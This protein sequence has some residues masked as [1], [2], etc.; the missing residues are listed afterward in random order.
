LSRTVHKPKSRLGR[1]LLAAFGVALVVPAAAAAFT[2]IELLVVIAIVG[3]MTGVFLPARIAANDCDRERISV[4]VTLAGDL[5]A[6]ILVGRPDG[7]FDYHIHPADL[8]GSGPRGVSVRF[9]GAA[10]GT[11]NSGEPF[12]IEL[13]LIGSSDLGPINTGAEVSLALIPNPGERTVDARVLRIHALDPCD[14]RIDSSDA[15]PTVGAGTAASPEGFEAAA[16]GGTAAFAGAALLGF[17][18][19][20]SRR[21]RR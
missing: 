2:L 8:T 10:N 1:V 9:I 12:T 3:E 4:P 16:L 20:R 17:V 14:R 11:A 21:R 18:A 6:R 7:S 15:E 13:R 5:N 19:L